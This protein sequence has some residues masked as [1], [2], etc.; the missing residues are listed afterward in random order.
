M[1]DVTETI[2]R[3][4]RPWVTGARLHFALPHF[5]DFLAWLKLRGY[6]K[7]VIA[8]YVTQFGH[9]TQ[10][11]H[12]AGF[13]METIHDGYAAS[14]ASLEAEPFRSVKLRTGALFIIFLE[15]R[16]VIDP[17]PKAP[18][19][20]ETWPILGEYR[21][22]MRRNR[23]VTE[24]SLDTYQITLLDLM[25][26]VG[27]NP[28]SYSS[29]VVRDFVLWRAS[30]H[31]RA[32]ARM[33]VTATKSFLRYLV[34]TGQCPAGIDHAVPKVA[35]WHLAPTPHFLD[36][37]QIERVIAACSGESRLRDRA[38]VLLL[39]RL[40]LRA[41][42]VAN[43]E[44]SNIDWAGGRLAITGGKSQRSEWLPLPQDIGDAILSYLERGRPKLAS[45][46]VFVTARLPM[47][48]ITR[49]AVTDIVNSA[50]DRAGIQSA[51][52]GSH[53]LRH[54]AATAMLRHGVSLAGVGSVLR[55]R[56]PST[57]MLYA[58]VDFGLLREIAQPWA[59]RPTC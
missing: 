54:S 2:K 53:L 11:L 56:S 40:G 50:L 55:H 32:S 43:L 58:K 28:E 38:V 41:G 59:G 27:G 13:G 37:F 51:K 36:D 18:S 20:T 30:L 16:G 44:F 3:N 39:I 1:S 34:A 7:R 17:L 15:E 25:K 23:G 33:T 52:R 21:D 48:P 24:T 42:E 22:W 57:T 9:W 19:A 8:G 26:M 49:A 5:D 45:P 47:R 35:G 14:V 4:G 6:A 10:W 46:N 31:G 29:T 12:E